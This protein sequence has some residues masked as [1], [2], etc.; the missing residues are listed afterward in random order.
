MQP[1]TLLLPHGVGAR[2][3]HKL[4]GVHQAV[5]V[6]MLEVFPVFI[7]LKKTERYL[8]LKTLRAIVLLPSFTR[9]SKCMVEAKT[10][11]HH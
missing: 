1:H 8:S 11:Q 2:F 3:D 5:F 7:D 6:H 4:R 10:K 9:N